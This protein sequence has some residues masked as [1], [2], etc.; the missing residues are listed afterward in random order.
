MEEIKEISSAN[1]SRHGLIKC[2]QRLY[3]LSHVLD[4]GTGFLAVTCP[5][6]NQAGWP[7]SVLT[8]MSIFFSAYNRVHG[9]QL[10]K[11]TGQN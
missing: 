8:G 11:A 1:A 4:D 5:Y 9:N 2:S 3:D 10:R 7:F 6:K